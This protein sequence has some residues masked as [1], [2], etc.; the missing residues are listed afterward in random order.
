MEESLGGSLHAG[1]IYGGEMRRERC[2]LY[3]AMQCNSAE[4]ICSIHETMCTVGSGP[5]PYEYTGFIRY[6]N[7]NPEL[8]S[9]SNEKGL[10]NAS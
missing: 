1:D 7:S 4:I 5:H 8:A 10:A 2:M 6:S 3:D 9:D